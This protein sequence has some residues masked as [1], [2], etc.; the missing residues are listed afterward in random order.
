MR[1]IHLLVL[2]SCLFLAALSV[3]HDLSAQESLRFTARTDSVAGALGAEILTE[4]YRRMGIRVAFALRPGL[5]AIHEANTGQSDGEV[6]RLKFVLKKYPNLRMV[7]EILMYLD[8]VIATTKTDIKVEGWKTVKKYSA[9]TVM[10]YRS[11]VQRIKD[12]PN[13]VAPNVEA[14][15]KML[16][17]GRIEI[18]VLSRL[19]LLR[20]LKNSGLKTINILEPPVSRV[21]LYHMLN[22]KHEA[23]APKIA[24]ILKKMKSDGSHQKIID[25]FV[26]QFQ[27]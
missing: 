22:K 27:Y 5:R 18:V 6:L 26:R 3:K 2:A 10:G 9:G 11:I 17:A 21:P 15:L 12:Q 19:D 1:Q 14:V 25:G 7:P 4:A 8:A 23:L 20:G 16:D 13:A 24:G